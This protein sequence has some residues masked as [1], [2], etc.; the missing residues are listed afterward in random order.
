L[1]GMGIT[2]IIMDTQKFLGGRI[3]WKTPINGLRLGGSFVHMKT[4]FNSI[5]S[6]SGMDLY[7][8]YG[9]MKI[10]NGFFLS[11]EWA[12]GN[13]TVTSEY[14]EL[15]VK[16]SLD[17]SGQKESEMEEVLSDEVM[18]GFYVMGSYLF[19]DKVT[20]YTY[21]DRFYADKGD[22]EGI[23]SIKL[24]NPNYFAWQKDI[25]FGVRVDVNFNWTVKA[26]WHIINGLS[27]SYVF[28]DD[29]QNTQQKWNMFAAKLAYNF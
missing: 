22:Y 16:L 25:V 14:M 24:G 20:L 13:F 2:P 27:K 3:I 9:H 10:K 21:Y 26:E 11:G 28:N 8:V 19:G 12:I 6:M 4:E 15:P 17:M 5:L 23:S 1:Y 18:Q 7:K 29:L